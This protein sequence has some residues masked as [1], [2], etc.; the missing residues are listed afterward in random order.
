ME[1]A[2]GG[3]EIVG[4][5]CLQSPPLVLERSSVRVFILSLKV[6]AIVESSICCNQSLF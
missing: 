5:N 6:D 2:P 4:K 1:E 3:D